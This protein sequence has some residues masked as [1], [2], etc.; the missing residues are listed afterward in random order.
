VAGVV[1][2]AILFVFLTC[3][4][5]C[6]KPGAKQKDQKTIKEPLGKRDSLRVPRRQGSSPE[7]STADLETDDQHICIVIAYVF[8][9]F[10]LFCVMIG[11]VIQFYT[12]DS[13]CYE[14]LE[15]TVSELFLGYEILAYTSVVI[16]SV[17]GCVLVCSCLGIVIK[18]WTRDMID[19]PP[20]I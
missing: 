8:L 18:C 5:F 17:I 15:E 4:E 10:A 20:F 13:S 11:S 3:V 12:L 1:A 19:D 16:L 9:A 2:I 14:H 7:Y 6:L